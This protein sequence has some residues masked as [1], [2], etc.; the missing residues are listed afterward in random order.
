MSEA[1]PTFC[2]VQLRAIT[3]LAPAA[4]GV[5]SILTAQKY[6]LEAVAVTVVFLPDPSTFGLDNYTFVVINH[7]GAI[8]VRQPMVMVPAAEGAWGGTAN[9]NLEAPAAALGPVLVFA[10]NTAGLLGPQVAGGTLT[11]CYESDDSN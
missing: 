9:V 3:E 1:A 4:R 11:T 10:S 2:S 6:N 8:V 7:D 5:A